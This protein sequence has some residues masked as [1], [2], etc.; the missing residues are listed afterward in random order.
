M[1]TTISRSGRAVQGFALGE[2]DLS[3]GGFHGGG[4]GFHGGWRGGGFRRGFAPGYYRRGLPSGWGW[5]GVPYV[6]A[7]E[8]L[9]VGPCAAWG[10][11]VVMPS[12]M[13]MAARVALGMSG[14][15]PTVARGPDGI[16]YRFAVVDGD[17]EVRPCFGQ[18]GMLGDDGCA[19]GVAGPGAS[20]VFAA[21]MTGAAV[22]LFAH[23]VRAPLWGAIVAGAA[24]AFVTHV[25]IERA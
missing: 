10:D 6:P 4:G 1:E 17:I 13:A 7:V 3:R 5:W 11:P 25:G 14:G 18:V 8:A 2:G 16:L 24:A 20:P 19:V 21:V 15:Q 23:V 9:P 22:G 12:G